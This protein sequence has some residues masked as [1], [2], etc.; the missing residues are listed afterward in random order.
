MAL[1]LFRVGLTGINEITEMQKLL[2]LLYKAGRDLLTSDK[3][4]RLVLTHTRLPEPKSKG[5]IYVTSTPFLNA[6]MIE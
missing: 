5:R 4:P 3:V 6:V 1:G 2:M